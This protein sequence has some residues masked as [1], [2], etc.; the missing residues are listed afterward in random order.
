MRV[1]LRRICRAAT[2]GV[3][4]V[5]SV[6]LVVGFVIIT[7]GASVTAVVLDAGTGVVGG[8]CGPV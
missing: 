3:V 1:V 7:G 6:L 4:V 8:V 2:V 5:G